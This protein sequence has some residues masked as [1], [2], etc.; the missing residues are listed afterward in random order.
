MRIHPLV[1]GFLVLA[2]FLGVVYGFQAIGIWSVTGGGES[3]GRDIQPMGS[4]TSSIKGWMTLGQITTTYHVT[5]EEIIQTFNLPADTSLDAELRSLES[6]TFS[7]SDL[8]LWLQNRT[9]VTKATP[10]A[11]PTLTPTPAAMLESIEETVDEVMKVSGN[12]TFQNLLDWGLTQETIEAVMGLPMPEP[13]LLIRD[14]LR[15]QGVQFSVVKEA[16]QAEVDQLK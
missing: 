2:V 16:L 11:V 14:Y 15:G 9:P 12:T 6:E 3:R 10:T 8:R 4:D 7:V 13:S 1:Y 5:L